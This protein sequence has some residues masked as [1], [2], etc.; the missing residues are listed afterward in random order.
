MFM[1]KGVEGTIQTKLL[2]E[3]KTLPHLLWTKRHHKA[4][5]STPPKVF[6]EAKANTPEIALLTK[7]EIL[8]KVKEF[9]EPRF[10]LN[11]L[12]S[13]KFTHFTLW[14]L[15][16]LSRFPQV[17]NYLEENELFSPDEITE[18]RKKWEKSRD[19]FL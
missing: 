15:K 9:T 16:E 1:E 8:E 10:T 4:V 7:E 5:G 6:V 19:E 3:A 12:L 14:W 17:F 2:E 13:Q 11:E 18:L